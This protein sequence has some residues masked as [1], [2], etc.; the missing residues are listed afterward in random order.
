MTSFRASVHI[1][2][3]KISD[4]IAKAE[5]MSVK[6]ERFNKLK[7]GLCFFV[8]FQ[9]CKIKRDWMQADHNVSF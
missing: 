2:V 1:S 6:I 4:K 7:F 8:L 9:H 3:N 5:A